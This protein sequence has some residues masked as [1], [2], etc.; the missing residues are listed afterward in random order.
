MTA[1]LNNVIG[2]LGEDMRRLVTTLGLFAVLFVLMAFGVSAKRFDLPVSGQAKATVVEGPVTILPGDGSVVQPAP[3]KQGREIQAP[4][5]VSVGQKGRLE[6]MLP[7][8]SFVRFASG[9]EFSL[10]KADA[11]PS[12]KRQ[13]QVDVALG[14]AWAKVKGALGEGSSF[15]VNSPTATAG[16]AGTTYRVSVGAQQNADFLVYEGQVKVEPWNP[17]QPYREGM[18]IKAPEKVAGPTQV[19]G[20]KRVSMEEWLYVVAAGYQFR[21]GP[22]G[23][24]AE[25]VRFDAAEDRKSPWVKWNIE[26]DKKSGFKVNY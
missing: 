5:K 6:L 19:E 10:V 22:D 4:T 9:T 2:I 18:T 15:K 20:P 25:P 12:G 26:R 8:G 11:A 13:V 23:R 21:I 1:L 24:P 7:D 3:L 17:D 14:D 16:V